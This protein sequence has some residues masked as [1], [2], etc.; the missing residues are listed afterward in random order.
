MTETLLAQAS[1]YYGLDWAAMI[2]TILFLYLIAKKNPIG[3]LVGAAGCGCWILVN[4]W[5]EIYAG[6]IL[7]IIL[8]GLN[9]HGFW[10][11][12]QDDARIERSER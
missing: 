7:N 6:V 3:F 10:K 4:I 5:V 2:L 11:W 1:N 8:L 12:K 9:L